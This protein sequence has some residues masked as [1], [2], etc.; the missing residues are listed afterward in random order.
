MDVEKPGRR[1]WRVRVIYIDEVFVINFAAD[2]Q[3]LLFHQQLLAQIL[4][5]LQ[6]LSHC[7]KWDEKNRLKESDNILFQSKYLI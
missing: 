2:T 3:L 1:G 7:E 4:N 5:I 6:F